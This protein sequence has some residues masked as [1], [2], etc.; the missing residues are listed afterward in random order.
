MNT[1][2]EVVLDTITKCVPKFDSR[3]Q[4]KG[5]GGGGL[6]AWCEFN[7]PEAPINIGNTRDAQ[8]Y[9]VNLL[10]IQPVQTYGNYQSPY[11]RQKY[12]V[13]SVPETEWITN[14]ETGEQT[15]ETQV[16]ITYGDGSKLVAPMMFLSTMK[17]ASNAG[18]L[19]AARMAGDF[20]NTT[21]GSASKGYIDTGLPMNAKCTIEA[22]GYIPYGID[23]TS[24]MGVLVGAMYNNS[25][26]TVARFLTGSDKQ[27]LCW[28]SLK[29]MTKTTSGISCRKLFRYTQNYQ[30]FVL[31]D[32]SNDASYT[33]THTS[34]S[35]SFAS[36]G[37]NILLFDDQTSGA[38]SSPAK[39]YR[40]G[41][42]RYA[43]IYDENNTLL[44]YLRPAALTS[45]EYVFIDLA[46]TTLEAATDEAINESLNNGDFDAGGTYENK[47][48]R[49]QQGGALVEVTEEEYTEYAS[50]L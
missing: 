8:G 33:V 49:P 1:V 12:A 18:V 32:V 3:Y 48:Y 50:S 15:M 27:Q 26:R 36:N 35:N 37:V 31:T 41:V 23:G 38:S 39:A 20:T 42:I 9:M 44:R 24:P 10:Q 19:W 14:D 28:A 22:E 25:A 6:A 34:W 30:E 29:E 2:L 5:E 7:L 11:V 46:G 43:K 13:L 17:L 47:V 45:G 4:K 21:T 16:I 40:N